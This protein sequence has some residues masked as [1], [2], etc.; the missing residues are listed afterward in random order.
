MLEFVKGWLQRKK[1]QTTYSIKIKRNKWEELFINKT[2][3]TVRVTF[4]KNQYRT[5]IPNKIK[6]RIN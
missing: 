3:F 6:K 5:I 1:Q 2:F 4:K